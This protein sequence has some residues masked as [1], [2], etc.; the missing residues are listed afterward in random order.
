M[1]PGAL[2]HHLAEQERHAEHSL[3][4]ASAVTI[5]FGAVAA[6]SF[7]VDLAVTLIFR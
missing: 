7:A 6:I 2:L 5:L 3:A 1:S 4:W